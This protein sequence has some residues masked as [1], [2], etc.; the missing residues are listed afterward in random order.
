MANVTEMPPL[1]TAETADIPSEFSAAPTTPA[2]Q[3]TKPK[4]RPPKG[5]PRPDNPPFFDKVAA[6]PRSDWGTRAYMYVYVDEPFCNPKAF[7]STRYL[8]KSS[9]PILDLEGLKQ[10]YGSFKGWMTL[11][12]R[13]TGKDQTDE[14]DRHE[15]EIYNIKHPPKIPRSAWANDPRNKRWLDLLPPEKPAA[16][17]GATTMIDAMRVYKEIRADVRDEV[18]KPEEPQTRASE[19]LETMRA[20]KDLF[21]PATT[22]APATPTDPFETAAKIMQMRANDPMTAVMMGLLEAAN[23]ATESAR[24]REFKLQQQLLEAKTVPAAAPAKGVIEQLLEVAQNAEKLEPIKKLFS[25]LFGGTGEAVAGRAAR[26]NGYDMVLN[27]AQSPFGANLGQGLGMLLSSLATAGSRAPVATNPAQPPPVVIS[28]QQPN[29]TVPPQES[30]EQRINRIGNQITQPMLYE[31]FL[32]DE[33]GSVWAERMFDMWPEDYVFMR[34]LGADNIVNRYRQFAPAWAIIGPK[35]PAFIQFMQEFCAW[36]PNAEEQ[37]EDGVKD[38]DDE[39][40][41]A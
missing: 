21:A 9:A 28:Q 19:V 29:T 26:T 12:C 23:K 41:G 5:T 17:E 30:T 7:G 11:N 33:P 32:K 20:A 13:K 38:L 16:S 14:M 27:I 15:F 34:G 4:G 36:D 1:E 31:F 18:S 10:D 6:V 35:E 22:A 2:P 24:E 37:A 8:L 25:G 40:V 39:G 3:P